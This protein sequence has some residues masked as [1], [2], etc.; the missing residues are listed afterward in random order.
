MT[1]HPESLPARGTAIVTGASSGIGAAYARRLAA[2]GHDLVLVAR[3][4]E[5]LRALAAELTGQHDVRVET[6]IADLGNASDLDR[7]ARRTA[8]DDVEL[9][10]NNAGINGYGPF[11]ETDTALLEKV[12]AV[13]VVALTRLARAAVPGMLARGCGAVVNVA[14][15]LAF[16]VRFRRTLCRCGRSMEGPRGTWS[17]SAEPSPQSWTV[18]R[19]VSRCCAPG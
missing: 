2:D 7:V 1:I 17:P 11:A 16:G 13:N 4:A 15:T 19:F 6:V 10:V 8:E 12:M 3:R 9:L 18:R 5:R 14:S